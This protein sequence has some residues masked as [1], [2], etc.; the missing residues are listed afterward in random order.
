MFIF[1]NDEIAVSKSDCVRWVLACV[2]A[3]A[4]ALKWLRLQESS[5]ATRTPVWLEGLAI[6]V[7]I[8]LSAWMMS[9]LYP[10]AARRVALL[11]FGVFAITSLEKAISGEPSCGCF[12]R[13]A[14][15]PW[16]TF[17][18][19][20]AAMAALVTMSAASSRDAVSSPRRVASW[21]GIATRV[22]TLACVGY[23]AVAIDAAWLGSDPVEVLE[24]QTWIGLPLP[25]LAHID[26]GSEIAKGR[27]RVVLI[28][29]DCSECQRAITKFQ[30][31]ASEQAV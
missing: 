5:I 24:P 25:L 17:L 1:Y 9:G 20:I 6:A 28:R 15:S 7:E 11:C 21:S 29:H 3:L 16:F 31:I 26:I 13:V 22:L 14:I 19:D 2:L 8:L 10:V 27:W 18:F 30:R 23:L 12:G 4:G